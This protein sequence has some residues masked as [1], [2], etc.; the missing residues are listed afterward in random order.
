MP[1]GVLLY[2]FDFIHVQI[3]KMYINQNTFER[4]G[5]PQNKERKKYVHVII[6]GSDAGF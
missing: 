4:T 6:S 3:Y 1:N 2:N 5:P